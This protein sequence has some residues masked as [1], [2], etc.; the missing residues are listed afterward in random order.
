MNESCVYGLMHAPTM[1]VYVG[2]TKQFS[3][4]RQFHQRHL[5]R[6]S[7]PNTFL[8]RAW[9]KY[10]GVGFVWWIFEYV[11]PEHLVVREQFWMSTG[12]QLFNLTSIAGRPPSQTGS[13]AN[14]GKKRTDEVKRAI[15][16]RLR[17]RSW[18]P[19][20]RAKAMAARKWSHLPKG[21]PF[22]FKHSDATRQKQ[23]AAARR[24]H[25]SV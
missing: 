19:E 16:E 1:R 12:L 7:H 13:T 17:G 3:I 14:R 15:A 20:R 8:Q 23:S 22:G 24:R 4:R 10:Q 21:R 18:T 2:S 25:R 5:S 6:G 9:N 11:A